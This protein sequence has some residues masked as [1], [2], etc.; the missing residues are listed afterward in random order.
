M[1]NIILAAAVIL[2]GLATNVLAANAPVEL[3]VHGSHISL[4]PSISAPGGSHVSLVRSISAPDCGINMIAGRCH[5]N[6]GHGMDGGGH[7]SHA[8]RR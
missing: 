6:S 7:E 3:M 8:S 2:P 1:R 4:V 5:P